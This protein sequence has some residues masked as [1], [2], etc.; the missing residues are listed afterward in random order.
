MLAKAHARALQWA[1][2]LLGGVLLGAVELSRG[3]LL[4]R[5]SFEEWL[6]VCHPLGSG[7]GLTPHVTLR[8]GAGKLGA[9]LAAAAGLCASTAWAARSHSLAASL[10]LFGALV[11][12]GADLAR[13]L[14]HPHALAQLTQLRCGNFGVFL[15][16]AAD[17]GLDPVAILQRMAEVTM[18]RGG[19]S[20]GVATFLPTASGL[21]SV[22]A[23]V[24][25][26]RRQAMA[27]LVASALRRR[28]AWCRF[29]SRAPGAGSHAAARVYLG[30]TRFATSSLPSVTE[31]HPHQWTPP[32]A[33]QPVWRVSHG[34][35][36]R[37]WERFS[38]FVTHNG[39]FDFLRVAG[40]DWPQ[41]DV[42]LW[43]ERL[44]HAPAPARCDS[45]KVAGCMELFR[46]QG[47]WG[48]SFRLAF[49]DVLA[50]GLPDAF[51][52]HPVTPDAPNAAPTV[53]VLDGL[54]AAAGAAFAR[55][56]AALPA[57][58]DAESLPA[59][60]EEAAREAALVECVTAALA[61]PDC[62]VE[63][64]AR[65]SPLRL[66]EL[67]AV[68]TAHFLRAD[69][70][71]ALKRFMGAAQGS[72]GLAVAC[73]L[74]V[75]RV[76]LAALNQPMGLAFA[77]DQGLVLYAS[78]SNAL[79]VPFEHPA[80][81]GGA[82]WRLDMDSVDGEVFEVRFAR[83]QPEPVDA[84]G[85]DLEAA[86]G[87]SSVRVSL[88]FRQS[89][90]LDAFA[91][92]PACG[93]RLRLHN[94][95]RDAPV[96][97]AQFAAA[98]RLVSLRRNPL[99]LSDGAARAG[100]ARPGAGRVEN[101]LRDTAR[102]I[103]R[104]RATWQ[105]VNGKTADALFSLLRQRALEA[106]AASEPARRAGRLDVDV[107]VTGVESSLW[108]AEQFASDLQSMFPH[109]RVV[110]LSANKVIG[111][112]GNARGAISTA[113]FS[114]CRLTAKL[115]NTVCIAMSHSGQT[116]PTLHATTILE[117][118]CPGRVFVVSG[119][120]DTKMGAAVG[121]SMAL[122]AP[123]SGRIF[124]TGAGWRAAE[125]ATVS[126][127]A[128]HH[129]LTELLLH[130]ARAFVQDAELARGGLAKPLGL[131]FQRQDVT[132]MYTVR[133]AF[134]TAAVPCLTG[135]DAL[136]G[137][138]R[139][140]VR[141]ELLAQG[142]QWGWNILESAVVWASCATYISLAVIFGV[143]FFRVLLNFAIRSIDP[144]S[145]ISY[146]WTRPDFTAPEWNGLNRLFTALY[147]LAGVLDAG[148]FIFLPSILT[149]LLRA[150][151][152]RPVLARIKGRRTLVIAD[153]PYVHQLLEMYVSKLFSLSFAVASVDVHGANGNDHFVHRFTHRVA[154][155]VMLAFGR[156]DGRMC[157]Q[158]KVESWTLMALLQARTIA[159]LGTGPEVLTLGH[160][161]Y[162]N[163]LMD[164][165]IV[166]PTHRPRM[167]CESVLSVTDHE[168][169][170]RLAA[171]SYAVDTGAAPELSGDVSH[172]FSAAPG[173]QRVFD[174]PIGAHLCCDA[175]MNAEWTVARRRA[176]IA[177]AAAAKY[178]ENTVHSSSSALS[179][180]GPAGRDA[181]LNGLDK[182]VLELLESQAALEEFLENRFL[183]A[184]RY[185]GF[186]VLFH[187]MAATVA[188]FPPLRFDT[189]RSQSCL[190][191]ATTAAPISAADLVRTY[192]AGTAAGLDDA[193]YHGGFS[194]LA[195]APSLPLK[196]LSLKRGAR[197]GSHQGVG[198]VKGEG[199]GESS[200][201][202]SEPWW[203]G[204]GSGG[205]D[206]GSMQ[207]TAAA[208]GLAGIS[209]VALNPQL[210]TQEPSSPAAAVDPAVPWWSA[211]V[212]AVAS[213]VVPP[214]YGD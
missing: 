162:K 199:E 40:R 51:D 8:P 169:M 33:A 154:R 7:V 165:A 86:D 144:G 185:L 148:L 139:T 35:A 103:D 124:S 115:D 177:S 76:A 82:A 85:A 6:R 57:C 213:G 56:A 20:G 105:L 30:H 194:G 122:G 60:F 135:V 128:M 71:Y 74:D 172:R 2:L 1:H 209:G 116:F 32:G 47:L 123:F 26:G 183:S 45:A 79:A 186:L 3:N 155:G 137:E 142:R 75:D 11:S 131:R 145:H 176:A 49:Q 52:F 208:L 12:D 118:A 147:Y 146:D 111:V 94:V 69:L 140:H 106:T 112:L 110:A 53:A 153:V 180:P 22:R 150:V 34:V 23:R 190:R 120:V 202:T 13:L 160:N 55:F 42:G 19:Q 173:V 168:P 141:D 129:L 95:R 107:L 211:D 189:S 130:L 161:P 14:M 17:A 207:G 171:L 98:G 152:G 64:G 181:V 184:E 24:R 89:S 46:A 87:A 156:P 164:R 191:V 205:R 214:T 83:A 133:D 48:A 114:F 132:D 196:A 77:P 29:T 31:S 37:S 4:C 70:F 91:P 174:A 59:L 159:N 203:G 166:L 15:A 179:V 65:L 50:S 38:L 182:P 96:S 73:S 117:R 36:V 206:G 195:R 28:L 43:L 81:A 197:R 100:T 54:A 157:S 80:S 198:G 108:V 78:E 178:E 58:A 151:Q 88:S 62:A 212:V 127:L 84:V 187:A 10:T 204:S 119:A 41:G 109:L 188:A 9:A 158:T 170:A 143:P 193:S 149:C 39:D 200:S 68:A 125:P 104:L 136:G 134:V 192:Q 67:A 63:V 101:D 61:A 25:P 126:A 113:G 175:A 16:E 44:L 5:L 97:A 18:G 201:W 66:R 167:L 121:Q 92:F 72:F 138:V 210:A 102:V 90:D 99:I 93:V 21:A 27:P 163:A